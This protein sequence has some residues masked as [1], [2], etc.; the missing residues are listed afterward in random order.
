MFIPCCLVLFL[1]WYRECVASGAAN[2]AVYMDRLKVGLQRDS[3]EKN[4]AH[5]AHQWSEKNLAHLAHQKSG[6]GNQESGGRSAVIAMSACLFST[7]CTPC[8][9]CEE[10]R[11]FFVISKEGM[12]HPLHL[13]GLKVGRSPDACERHGASSRWR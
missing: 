1:V 3:R 6:V 11:R 2:W 9:S 7:C 13:L 8:T 5:L 10:C 12:P 4:L